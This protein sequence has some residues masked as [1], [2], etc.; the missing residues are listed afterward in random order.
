MVQEN[1]IHGYNHDLYRLQNLGVGEH[2]CSLYKEEEDFRISMV[3]FI[4]GGLNQNQKV[5]YIA[6]PLSH[7]RVISYLAAADID[8]VSF[9]KKAVKFCNYGRS[10]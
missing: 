6:D 3:D 1:L 5:N 9:E 10:Y 4:T 8:I 2:V 7:R